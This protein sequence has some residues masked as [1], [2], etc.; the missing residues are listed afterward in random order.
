MTN[1]N[2]MHDMLPGK[3]ATGVVHFY[4]DSS[5]L[6]MWEAIYHRNC[7]VWIWISCM[8]N[9]FWANHWSSTIPLTRRTVHGETTMLWL[10]V[11]LFWMQSYINDITFCPFTLLEVSMIACGGCI[12]LQHLK[13]ECNIANYEKRSTFMFHSWWIVITIDYK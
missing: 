12:N 4:L 9:L 5:R 3:A 11:L 8:P 2:L 6:V 10:I 13:S 1:V 7:N